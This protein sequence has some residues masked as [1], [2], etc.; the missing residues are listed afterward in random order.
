[1]EEEAAFTVPEAVDYFTI[2]R[3]L[4]VSF[5]GSSRSWNVLNTRAKLD[6]SLTVYM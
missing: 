6:V 5:T 2:L 3:Q 1:V 4:H